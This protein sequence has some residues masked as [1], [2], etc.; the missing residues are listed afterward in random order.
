MNRVIVASCILV[1]CGVF[2]GTHTYQIL[3]L[4]KDTTVLC[5]EV[6]TYFEK[7]NWE[8]VS[9]GLKR[10]QSRWDRSRFWACMTIDTAEI[11]EMEI[12]LRQAMKY[13]D[14]EA[15]PDFIGEF[16]MFRM[17]MGHLPHQEGFSIEELL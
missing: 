7:E 13:A 16:T 11:E 8:E 10:I 3:K 4:D 6:E 1:L 15:K 14:E 2:V 12:S 17:R 9:K 5:E